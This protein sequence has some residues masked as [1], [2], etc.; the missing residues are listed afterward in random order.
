M[1]TISSPWTFTA[2]DNY[3]QAGSEPMW[4]PY[5]NFLSYNLASDK[6]L[7]HTYDRGR[8]GFFIGALDLL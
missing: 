4:N 5:S 6:E 8:K 2:D 7:R 1:G 3:H